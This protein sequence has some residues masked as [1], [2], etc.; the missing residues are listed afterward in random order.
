MRMGIFAFVTYE[1]EVKPSAQGPDMNKIPELNDGKTQ[2][3]FQTT[4][5]PDK[6]L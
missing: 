5:R 3:T 1:A 4:I 6:C 2:L